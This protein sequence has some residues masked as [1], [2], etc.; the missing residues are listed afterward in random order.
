MRRVRRR[1]PHLRAFRSAAMTT[2]AAGTLVNIAW[3]VET[4][5][6]AI[7]HSTTSNPEVIAIQYPGLYDVRATA[8][9]SGGS[10]EEFRLLV[11]VNSGSGYLPRDRD[12]MSGASVTLGVL[13]VGP[14]TCRSNKELVL[15]AGDLLR[16]RCGTFGIA[17]VNVPLVVGAH[18]T[19]LSIRRLGRQ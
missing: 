9:V 12:S 17:G 2:G 13:T 3:D 11:E 6:Y 5:K 8:N 16:V 10:W 18:A 7:G 1:Q 15:L 14:G 19:W 4:S